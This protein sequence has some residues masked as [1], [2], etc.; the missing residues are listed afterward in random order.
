MATTISSDLLSKAIGKMIVRQSDVLS[1][2]DLKP[3]DTNKAVKVKVYRKWATRNVT[4]HNPT[5]F[6]CILLDQKETK[7][8]VKQVENV[9]MVKQKRIS[10]QQPKVTPNA[11]QAHNVKRMLSA[12]YKCRGLHRKDIILPSKRIRRRFKSLSGVVSIAGTDV[13]TCRPGD[14][15]EGD[16]ELMELQDDVGKQLAPS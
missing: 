5:A 13:A 14:K 16:D 4:D 7:Q 15:V 8:D 12:R 6:C 9:V 11:K 3:T 10:T 1:V 2:G